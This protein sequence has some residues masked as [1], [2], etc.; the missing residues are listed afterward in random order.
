MTEDLNWMFRRARDVTVLP[1]L[2]LTLMA[3]SACAPNA[4]EG[5]APTPPPLTAMSGL[6]AQPAAVP[7]LN[8]Q[9]LGNWSASYP[10]GPYRV[11]IQN[12]P[13]IGGTSYVATLDDGGYGTFHAGATVFNAVPDQVVPNLVTGTQKCPDP[14]YAEPFDV[15]VT[16]TVVDANN[17]TEELVHKDA[18]KGYP[19]KFTRIAG[20]ASP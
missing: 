8:Q 13:L 4:G 5:A 6:P 3:L 20:S 11:T 10:G 19:V 1:I 18:C 9:L 16:I 12:N 14:V 17:F 7:N 15:S 2:C